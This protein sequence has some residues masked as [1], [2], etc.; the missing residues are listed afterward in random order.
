MIKISQLNAV[1]LR[2]LY[3]CRDALP[4]EVARDALDHI[5]RRAA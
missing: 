5:E 2:R 4:V 1:E 3:R